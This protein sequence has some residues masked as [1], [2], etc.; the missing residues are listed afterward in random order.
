MRR[1]VKAQAIICAP[2]IHI[3]LK[4]QTLCPVD[5]NMHWSESRLDLRALSWFLSTFGFSACLTAHQ[6][7]MFFF[8]SVS[9]CSCVSKGRVCVQCWQVSDIFI[10]LCYIKGRSQRDTQ[11]RRKTTRGRC[12]PALHWNPRIPVHSVQGFDWQSSGLPYCRPALLGMSEPLNQ[13]WLPD[14]WPNTC[15][16]HKDC[17][18]NCC[19]NGNGTSDSNMTTYSRPGKCNTRLCH[20]SYD[21]NKN[22]INVHITTGLYCVLFQLIASPIMGTMLKTHSTVLRRLFTVTWTSLTSSVRL[23]CFPTPACATR[24]QMATPQPRM[25]PSLTPPHSSFRPTLRIKQLLP[26]L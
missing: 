23:K 2:F 25:S 17:S 22:Q 4:S 20:R 7:L 18:I 8:S 5:G 3:K 11:L 1:S 15:A 21:S 9:L 26:V 6:G 14:S 24:V 19:N 12:V 16:N 13:L 10:P